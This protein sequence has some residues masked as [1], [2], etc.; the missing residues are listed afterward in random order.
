M[1]L[2]EEEN[3]RI[4]GTTKIT[5]IPKHLVNERVVALQKKL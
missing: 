5:P 4:Y 3:L 2:L 1:T